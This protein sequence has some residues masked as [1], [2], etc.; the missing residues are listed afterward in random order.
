MQATVQ[1]GAVHA[2]LLR[3][4]HRV[5]QAAAQVLVDGLTCGAGTLWRL[6]REATRKDYRQLM[7]PCQAGP[8]YGPCTKLMIKQQAAAANTA[9]GAPW[10]TSPSGSLRG[11]PRPVTPRVRTAPPKTA[12]LGW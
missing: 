9:T 1:C 2:C 11:P 4:C 3:A 10:D 5:G 8:S 6:F 7:N 12:M